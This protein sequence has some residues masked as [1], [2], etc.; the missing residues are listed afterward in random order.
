MKFWGKEFLLN[1][2][3]LFLALGALFFPIGAAPA[4]EVFADHTDDDD[5][6]NGGNGSGPDP[7]NGGGPFFCDGVAATITGTSGKDKLVGTNGPD[8]IVGLAGNDQIEGKGGADIIC[9]N[10]GDD[11]L[12]G[13]SGADILIGGD[14][15]DRFDGGGGID[16]CKDVSADDRWVRRCEIINGELEGPN[17]PPGGG[18]EGTD[19]AKHHY[20]NGVPDP[21]LGRNN[22]LYTDL[23]TGDIYIKNKQGWQFQGS[24]GGGTSGA[25]ATVA[26]W[27]DTTSDLGL[28]RV[29]GTFQTSETIT[30]DLGVTANTV[31]LSSTGVAFSEIEVQFIGNL[32]QL[33]F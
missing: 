14:G 4:T 29:T 3:F 19:I 6:G 2:I 7:P 5:N 13:N 23:D 17:A 15:R 9:G 8:V 33:L 12:R 26:S 20:G 30:S 32:K 24:V 18:T 1:K 10:E 16:A 22:D 28:V 21:D 11:L 31:S 27:D 25:T